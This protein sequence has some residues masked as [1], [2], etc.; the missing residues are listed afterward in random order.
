[1]RNYLL[2]QWNGSNEKL[3]EFGRKCA[4]TL[5]DRDGISL[6]LLTAY[7]TIAAGPGVVPDSPNLQLDPSA[8]KDVESVVGPATRVYPNNETDWARY[9]VWAVKC[10]QWKIAQAGFGHMRNRELWALKFGG[11]GML[12]PARAKAAKLSADQGI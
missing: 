1:M 4:A 2:P 10:Q 7:L 8:W 6:E 5:D 11:Y 12:L 3:I 9:T